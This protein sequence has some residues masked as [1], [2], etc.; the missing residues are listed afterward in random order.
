MSDEMDW[1][2]K[3]LKQCITS[4]LDTWHGTLSDCIR[5]Q[6]EKILRLEEENKQLR[7][8]N[9]NL[10]GIFNNHFVSGG[11]KLT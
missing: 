5:S 7:E 2:L 4:H 6:K 1:E 9:E 10:I 11:E 3:D 8:E